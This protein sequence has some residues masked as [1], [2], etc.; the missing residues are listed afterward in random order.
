M[1]EENQKSINAVSTILSSSACG[2]DSFL[3]VVLSMIVLKILERC[4]A[5]AH[6]QHEDEAGRGWSSQ[7]KSSAISRNMNQTHQRSLSG[8]S[9]GSSRYDA[10]SRENSVAKLVLGELH[11]VQRLVNELSK[12][13]KKQREGDGEDQIMRDIEKGPRALVTANTLAQ[14]ETDMRKSLRALSSEIIDRLRHR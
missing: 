6:I 10:D 14:L 7:L 2:E 13:I 8:P 4:D 3:L 5:A 9:T 11:R 12:E 1:L